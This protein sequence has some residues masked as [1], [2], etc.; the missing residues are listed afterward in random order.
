MKLL[1]CLF[2]LTAI[3]LLSSCSSPNSPPE[4]PN[5]SPMVEQRLSNSFDGKRITENFV[6]Q[7]LGF[8][9]HLARRNCRPSNTVITDSSKDCL[10]IIKDD[11]DRTVSEYYLINRSC[12]SRE[13][14]CHG[15][16]QVAMRVDHVGKK[17]SGAPKIE[18]ES[19]F[20]FRS[21]LV[22]E[23][24]RESI[25][26][27]PT[28]S[29]ISRTIRETYRGKINL[30]YTI[31]NEGFAAIVK[32]QLYDIANNL[33]TENSNYITPP[34]TSYSNPSSS[35]QLI[36]S[37]T[38]GAL[39]SVGIGI[40]VVG[41]AAIGTVSALYLGIIGGSL[42]G[43]AGL[44]IGAAVSG[45]PSGGVGLP[46]GAVGGFAIGTGTGASFGIALGGMIGAGVMTGG[47]ALS[48]IAYDLIKTFCLY[49]RSPPTLPPGA[50]SYDPSLL[51]TSMMSNNQCLAC[52]SIESGSTAVCTESPSQ[53][54]CTIQDITFCSQTTLVYGNDTDRD[55]MCD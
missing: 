4:N 31:V 14:M 26:S 18:I 3:T 5:T 13:K 6:N 38:A 23:K 33:L 9:S 22:D 12:S 25:L 28:S 53:L 47:A 35:D 39:A 21:D 8:G 11:G 19:K 16:Y 46:A 41:G 2:Y 7:T 29:P 44:I 52:T 1:S 42:G 43:G 24:N 34:M 17:V 10:H 36:C 48:A 49:L 54:D 45:A 27:R 50:P 20:Y 37:G 40:S 30:S 55:G 15:G 51:N 32:T